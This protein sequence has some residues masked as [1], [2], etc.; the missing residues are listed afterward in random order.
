M[1]HQKDS[2]ISLTTAWAK[3]RATAVDGGGVFLDEAAEV[4]GGLV[5]L[6]EDEGVVAVEDVAVVGGEEDFGGDGDEIAGGLAGGGVVGE[7][8]TVWVRM[9]PW[10]VASASGGVGVEDVVSGAGVEL[11]DGG[12]GE[13]HLGVEGLGVGGED[14]DGEGA[15]AGGDVGGGAG[16]VVAA[17]GEQERGRE[18]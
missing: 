5:L 13:G 17:A 16:G 11:A 12:L 14:G 8:A 2:S 15:D 3:S 4:L 9:V 6:A 7:G 10:R 1:R 18:E